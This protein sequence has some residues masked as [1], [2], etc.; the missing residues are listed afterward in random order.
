M[1]VRIA[2][3]CRATHLEHFADAA[4]GAASAIASH[5]MRQRLTSKVA[6]DLRTCGLSAEFSESAHALR[7]M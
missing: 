2:C 3:T 1:C 5:P 6:Q 4:E 7:Q